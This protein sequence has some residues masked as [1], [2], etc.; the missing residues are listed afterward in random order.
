MPLE[1]AASPHSC[2]REALLA[3]DKAT[4]TFGDIEDGF[5]YGRRKGWRNS[6]MEQSLTERAADGLLPANDKT[7]WNRLFAGTL[8]QRARESLRIAQTE[9]ASGGFPF[10]GHG[11]LFKSVHDILPCSIRKAV[12][13]ELHNLRGSQTKPTAVKLSGELP[14]PHI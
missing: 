14:Q 5:L 4:L 6:A 11:T 13:R 1:Y 7:M 10:N 2:H 3:D 9:I 8:P 12:S